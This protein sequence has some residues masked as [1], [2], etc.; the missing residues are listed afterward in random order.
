MVETVHGASN[1]APREE[2]FRPFTANG[3]WAGGADPYAS[4]H[5]AHLP[6]QGK[7][8]TRLPLGIIFIIINVR[9]PPCTM[10]ICLPRAR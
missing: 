3:A 2:S 7:V 9:M 10:P 5:H 4:L 1:K 8:S 6:A